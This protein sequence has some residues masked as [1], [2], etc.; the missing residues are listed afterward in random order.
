MVISQSR[1]E[2]IA[3]SRALNGSAIVLDLVRSSETYPARCASDVTTGVTK[4]L[5]ADG[6]SDLISEPASGSV[7]PMLHEASSE[8]GELLE[9]S[10]E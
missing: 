1:P 10:Q 3:A 7:A 6:V 5:T 8:S 4:P 2:F 9:G